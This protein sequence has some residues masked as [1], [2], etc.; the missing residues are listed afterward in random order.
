MGVVYEAVQESLGRHVALKVLSSHALD[1]P[2]HRERFRREARAA[3]RLHHT[4][5]VPVFGV[6]EHQGVHYYA[7]QFIHG[8]G[9]HEVLKEVR[10]LRGSPCP[11]PDDLGRGSDLSV[12]I[13]WGLLSGRCLIGAVEGDSPPG[14]TATQTVPGGGTCT[15][16]RGELGLA[17]QP[18]TQYFRSV[19]MMGVQV[20][21][22]LAYAHRQRILHRDIKPSNL[23]LDARGTV[24]VTDFGLV[25]EEG[26]EELTHAGDIVGTLRYM[27][28]ERFRGRADPRSDVY[29]LG[30]TLYEL[31]TL[32]PAF[33]DS[34]R[35]RLMEQVLH[36]EPVRP[37]RL[38][39]RISRDLETIVLKAMA[40]EPGDRYPCAEA[41]AEDLRRFVTDRPILARR[42]SVFERSRRWCRRNPALA[43]AGGLAVV[44]LGAM[45]ALGV[46]SVF[47]LRLSREQ[48]QTAAALERAELAAERLR[49]EEQKTRAALTQAEHFRG[50]A[51]R[52]SANLALERG[53]V[54]LEQGE[55][56][57]GMLWLTRSLEITPADAADLQRAIRTNL[58]A[59]HRQLGHR[60]EMVLEEGSRRTVPLSKTKSGAAHLGMVREE[61][62]TIHAVALSPDGKTLLTGSAT[63]RPRLWH[64]ATGEPNGEPLPHDG[65][66]RAAAFSPD[67]RTVVTAGFDRTARLWD[68]HTRKPLGE[69][70]RHP[71]WVQAVA[72]SPDSKI[73]VTGCAANIEY[74]EARRWEA[75]T[76]NLIGEP[77]RHGSV[78]RAVALSGDG[79]TL[80]TGDAFRAR[81]WD[82]STG[83]SV[84]VLE[85]PGPI[86]AA[87]F[88]PDQKTM[89]TG[90]QE[91]TARLWDVATRKPVGFPLQ[92]Q[93]PVL[94]AGFGP[95]GKIVWTGSSD[96][97]VRRWFVETARLAEMP[98]QH[99]GAVYAVAWSTDQQTVVT[100]DTYGKIRRWKTIAAEHSGSK[101]TREFNGIQLYCVAFGPDGRT[102]AAAGS[103]GVAYFWEPATGKAVGKPLYHPP[104]VFGLAFSPDGRRILTGSMDRTCRQWDVASGAPLDPLM[105]HDDTVFAVAFSPDGRSALT[106]SRDGTA[107]LWDLT[108]GKAR[109]SLQH[110]HWVRTVAF[111]PDGKF[112][113]TGCEDTG[114]R[115][116][117]SDT[118]ELLGEP[119]WDQGPVTAL[120]FSL[121]GETILSGTYYHATAR[122]WDVRTRRQRGLLPH[123]DHVVGAAFTP[124]NLTIA[125]ACWDGAARLW[126][127]ATGKP[128][129]QPLRHQREVR[130]VAFSP[131]GR[132][133]LTGSFDGTSRL[134]DVPSPVAGDMERITLWVQVL[135]GMELDR[136]GLFQMSDA[137]AWQQHSHRLQELGG[138]PLP[139]LPE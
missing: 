124:D 69:P 38:D 81:L 27:A 96:G 112:L 20:A 39:P 7:M 93:G 107:R 116:W 14:S 67:G 31:L 10:R 134:W 11:P 83:R 113:L 48:A 16:T 17:R 75:A 51:E 33:D 52:A 62:S 71:G 37:C 26:V 115:L 92:H 6:G 36:E 3:A 21:E 94:T 131:D 50:L 88:S 109:A 125:T 54:L 111:S 105:Q 65:G 89:V 85:H 46:G 43:A 5:I 139:E 110:P 77:L 100:G 40:C 82:V 66:I 138:P 114:V 42:A 90:S 19:A 126:D 56:G 119:L 86:W 108:T 87:A 84:E 2:T 102:V 103:N 99:Q 64:V 15:G 18:E 63:G 25:K 4:N 24:W 79:K 60:L 122:L 49:T 44:A 136:D 129:G 58:A 117:D 104:R 72:F 22:A 9:L 78:V 1:S 123:R 106:G 133:L 130:A 118:G 95:D 91:G 45:I 35:G 76:G 12:S 97:K 80:L 47:A 55:V 23:L 68:A 120:A 137:A 8:P 98:I 13:A 59:A 30:V 128:I 57:R 101:S 70:L 127:A 74:G 28:P 135:T 73:L 29:G 53:M 61:G 34:N 32:Q 41:L 121:D 132:L